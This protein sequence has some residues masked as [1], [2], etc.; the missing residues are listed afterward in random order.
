MLQT[1]RLS[2]GTGRAATQASRASRPSQRSI[3]HKAAQASTARQLQRLGRSQRGPFT[4]RECSRFELATSAKH[5][6][7]RRHFHG[8]KNRG[9]KSPQKDK[10]NKEQL[11]LTPHPRLSLTVLIGKKKK[12]PKSVFFPM[13]IIFNNFSKF[14]I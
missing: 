8:N 5:P 3:V 1:C 10:R 9:E 6:L 12:R 11:S 14:V 2:A 13:T 7:Q 4:M